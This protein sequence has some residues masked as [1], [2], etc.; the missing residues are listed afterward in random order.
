MTGKPNDK[1]QRSLISSYDSSY[2]HSVEHWFYLR[3]M[4]EEQS[5]DLRESQPEDEAMETR[6][7]AVGA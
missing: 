4:V 5:M 7:R 1:N 3:E 2:E 6:V